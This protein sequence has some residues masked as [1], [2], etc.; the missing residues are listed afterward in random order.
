MAEAAA[1]S[2][3]DR[4]I[5]KVIA[6]PLLRTQESAAPIAAQFGLDIETDPRIIEPTN[7]FEG[8]R[9]QFGLPLLKQPALWW[10]VRNPFQPSWGEPYTEIVARMRAA[11][12]DAFESVEDG[13]VALVSHQLPIW[14]VH[15][16]VLG[17][18][19]FHDPRHRR[20]SLSSIT[21]FRRKDGR[22]V[23]TG[24]NAAAASLLGAS[25]D[26]GAV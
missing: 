14:M 20:C 12:V 16:S 17:A 22:I 21:T 26:E 25:K 6:S 11:I 19:L 8:K 1:A 9:V 3:A 15:R 4:D 13:E 23:E 18:P 10:A 5:R 2:L 7:A 24:Y